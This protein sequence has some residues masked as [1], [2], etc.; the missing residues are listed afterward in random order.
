L[1]MSAGLGVGLLVLGAGG[2]IWN[3]REEDSPNDSSPPDLEIFRKGYPRAFFF[4]QTETEAR[5]GNL[6]YEMW[7]KRYLPLNGIVGKV[8]DESSEHSGKYD[9]LPF[10]LQY[11]ENNPSKAVLLHYHGAGRRATDTTTD[12]FAGHWFYYKGTNLTRQVDASPDTTLLHVEDTSVFSLDRGVGVGDDIAIAP[13]GDDGKPDWGSAE[14]ARLEEIDAENETITVERGAYGT[15]PRFFS[16]GSYLAA[17]VL[18]APYPSESA[19][20]RDVTLWSYNFSTIGPRDDKGRNGADALVDYLAEKL[21][22]GG[23]LATFDGLVFDVLSFGVRNGHPVADVDVD[24]DGVEDGGII[25]GVDVVGLGTIEFAEALRERLP[26]K[27]I[28]ADGQK[29]DKSQRSFQF[30]N[31]IESEG[32]PDIDDVELDHLSRG[33][34]ILGFWKENSAAPSVNYVSFKY[35]DRETEKAGRNTFEKSNSS[36][37]QSYRKLRLVLALTQFA[38]AVFTYPK[39]WAPPETLW[40]QENV[41][42]RVFDELWQGVEQNPNWLGMPQGAAVHLATES[43][44]LLSGQGESWSQDLIERM[45]GEGVEFSKDA[46]PAMVVETTDTNSDTDTPVLEK[47]MAF[48]LPEIDVPGEDLFVSLRLRADPLE[49]Y[50]A[51]IGRRVYLTATPN[52]DADQAVEEFT[53][54]N[55]KPFTAT[56]YFK[57]VGPGSVD[58]SFE[59]EGDRPVFF[60]RLSGHSA[61]D[62]MYR[63][64]ENGAVFANP[65][66]H[67]YTFDLG[68]L[69]PDASF[70]RLQGSGSQDPQTNDGQLLDE[71][72]TLGP[73]DGL[74]VVR[75]GG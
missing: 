67:P 29:P 47:T 17:H 6:S 18:T 46:S 54:T 25:D 1:G 56:F 70:R 69:F 23:P 52:G 48:T 65:S 28:M 32:F 22:P 24:T 42:V 35:V 30:L 7:E 37:D 75:S 51:S 59:V 12:F 49:S 50:P 36:E 71:Q 5:S 45:N 2:C 19:P 15:E 9:N 53:W 20:V 16:A 3:G 4:R 68:R 74:F 44:D 13:V 41:M 63:E 66:A 72:L 38:D 8:L 21:E 10:F 73:K 11:K 34:N 62:A 40:E 31:G 26:D 43:P 64:F 55:E 60:E 39:E 14:Q 33:M 58:L 27:I 61:T 57:D